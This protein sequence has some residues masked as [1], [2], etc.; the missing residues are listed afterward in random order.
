EPTGEAPNGEVED[1]LAPVGEEMP[2]IG[3]AKRAVS[4]ER[5]NDIES[6]VT[7]EILLENYGN[8]P[9]SDVNAIMDLALVFA[10]A[11]AWVLESYTSGEFV[12]N[13]TFDG[14]NDIDL[15]AMGN[16][17]EIGGQ[18]RIEVVVRIDPGN[19]PGP[20]VCSTIGR[21]TSPGGEEVDDESQDGEDPDP[22]DDGNPNDDDEPTVVILVIN[23]L[24]IPTLSQIGLGLL[25]L[26][27]AAAGMVT[28]RRRG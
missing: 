5:V 23:I 3:V 22:T 28:M 15:L 9:L 24:E 17:L 26:L 14:E 21:G 13:P 7:Y 19:N 16:T 20:Y 18:G 8:V 10:D 11:E 12:V 25:V 27:L 4:V 2:M 1:H 6:T